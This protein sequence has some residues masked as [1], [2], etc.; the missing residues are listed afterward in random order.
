MC[1]KGNNNST[2]MWL[3]LGLLFLCFCRRDG[4]ISIT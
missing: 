1:H 2:L 4:G 3:L